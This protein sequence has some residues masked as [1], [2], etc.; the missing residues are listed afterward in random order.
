MRQIPNKLSGNGV[1]HSAVNALID[2]VRECVPRESK[3]VVMERGPNGFI[4]KPKAASFSGTEKIPFR[5]YQSDTWLK[6]KVTTGYI[7][8]SGDPITATGIEVEKTI[9]GSVLR[10]WFY[11]E[12]TE[13]TAEIKTSATTLEWSCDIVPIGWVDTLTDVATTKATIYQLNRDHLFS[14]YTA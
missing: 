12:L 4:A 11:I 6:Y 9:T 7:V 5:I 3:D 8:R 14:P 13:T 2:C 10:Y 1:I